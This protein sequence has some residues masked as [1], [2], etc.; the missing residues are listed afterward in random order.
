MYDR[1]FALHNLCEGG[2]VDG[3]SGQVSESL[4]SLTLLFFFF[5]AYIQFTV[6]THCLIANAFRQNRCGVGLY[7]TT[8]DDTAMSVACC[9]TSLRQ[10][11]AMAQ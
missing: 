6:R 2:G 11:T 5:L 10:A 3:V 7:S 8:Q 9:G 4:V 1:T